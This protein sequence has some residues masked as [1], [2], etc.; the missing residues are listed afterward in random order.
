MRARRKP[1][2]VSLFTLFADTKGQAERPVTDFLV[3]FMSRSM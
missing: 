1:A 3:S 2:F